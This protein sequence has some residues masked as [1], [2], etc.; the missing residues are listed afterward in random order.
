VAAVAQLGAAD[1]RVLARRPAAAAELAAVGQRL[2]VGVA[3]ADW[4]QPGTALR[5]DL[6]VSTVPG[7]AA[8]A[9]AGEVPASPGVLLDV[10]Y[11]PWPTSLASAWLAAG[12]IAI[13]GSDMLLWQ[14]VRQVE[15]M[16]GRQAPVAAM[17]RALAQAI[18]GAPTA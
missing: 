17:Q 7:D 4:S 2:G 15:L 10:T 11:R 13:P 18:D 9:L 5:A 12:G 14:A 6:V 8:A 3:V 16:T 1:V